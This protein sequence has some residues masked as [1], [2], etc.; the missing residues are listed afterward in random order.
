MRR[1]QDTALV[2]GAL[3]KAAPNRLM[4][5]FESRDGRAVRPG[6]RGSRPAQAQSGGR[7]RASG[8]RAPHLAPRS[9]PPAAG[10]ERRGRRQAEWPTLAALTETLGSAVEEAGGIGPHRRCASRNLERQRAA[11]ASARPSAGR[12]DGQGKGAPGREGLRKGIVVEALGAEASSPTRRQ[13]WHREVV[14]SCW[15]TQADRRQTGQHDLVVRLVCAGLAVDRQVPALHLPDCA[16]GHE[17]AMEARRGPSGPLM[18]F[19]PRASRALMSARKLQAESSAR[20][21]RRRS[22]SGPGGPRSR[23]RGWLR[24]EREIAAVVRR[25]SA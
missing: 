4:M 15:P 12:E 9:S 7:R 17:R 24:Y 16:R 1:S 3:G 22:M 11:L 2:V 18:S 6:P 25:Q 19:G 14:D 8:H 10:T 20:S 13:C 21:G 23:G 5:Q